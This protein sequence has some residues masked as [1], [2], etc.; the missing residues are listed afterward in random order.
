MGCQCW[1]HARSKGRLVHPGRILAVTL[2]IQVTEVLLASRMVVTIA[3]PFCMSLLWMPKPKC[4]VSQ[5]SVGPRG[6][7]TMCGDVTVTSA[8]TDAA[9]IPTSQ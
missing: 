6:H 3:G 9:G 7:L 1:W 4:Y 5:Q 8:E 2:G